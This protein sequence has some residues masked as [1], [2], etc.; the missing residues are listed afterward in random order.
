MQVGDLDAI[1]VDE[2]DAADARGDEGRH[3]GA[4]ESARAEHDHVRI[5]EAALRVDAPSGK[6]AL[7]GVPGIGGIEGHTSIL[8][9]GMAQRD[10]GGRSS[11]STARAA[12]TL[13]S[14]R[15]HG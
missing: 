12:P 7:A 3:H 2:R 11:E 1:V 10:C 8:A 5:G 14:H 13:D 6:H 15:R 9:G 4:A